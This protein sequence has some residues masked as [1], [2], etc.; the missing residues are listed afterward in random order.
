MGGASKRCH[1][2]R[3]LPDALAGSADGALALYMSFTKSPPLP[4]SYHCTQVGVEPVN[5]VI[6]GVGYHI[7][8]LGYAWSTR[9]ICEL[10]SISP[11]PWPLAFY[12]CT[13]VWVE[14]VN[15]VIPGVGYHIRW[16]GLWME[17][18]EGISL[19]NL[20]RLGKPM[21]HPNDFLDIMHDRLNKTQVGHGMGGR[22]GRRVRGGCEVVGEGEGVCP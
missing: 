10:Y 3:G 17:Q 13:Q 11:T 20:V 8:W 9:P 15:G 21:M 5:G 12:H 14:P 19:E 2:K 4:A 6:P 16:L 1:L 18:A 7:R 22:G